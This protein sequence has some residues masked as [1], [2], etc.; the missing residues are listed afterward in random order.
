MHLCKGCSDRIVNESGFG[1]IGNFCPNC[2][3]SP[4]MTHDDLYMQRKLGEMKVE[5]LNNRVVVISS[6]KSPFPVPPLEATCSEA[7][8]F[9]PSPKNGCE[10]K[11]E[12]RM[13]GEHLENECLYVLTTCKYRCGSVMLKW[14]KEWHEEHECRKRPY[15]CW[16]CDMKATAEEIDKH[17]LECTERLIPCPNNCSKNLKQNKVAKHLELHCP[18]QTFS[19]IFSSVGC[20]KPLSRD[21]CVSHMEEEGLRHLD[22]LVKDLTA[23]KA[24]IASLK[25]SLQDKDEEIEELQAK[26]ARLDDSNK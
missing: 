21:E 4:L 3:K 9:P 19:C 24:E 22:L 10:W 11:G 18:L 1:T 5:C 16:F 25:R 15:Q 17:A 26:V 7:N 23:T 20:T 12:L 13:I 2:K 14:D 8:H 6:R